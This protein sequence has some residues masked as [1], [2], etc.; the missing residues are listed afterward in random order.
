MRYRN[1]KTLYKSHFDSLSAAVTSF[2]FP[3]KLTSVYMRQS[4]V[5]R[6]YTSVESANSAH[7]ERLT[8]IS[9]VIS[10]ALI[11]LVAFCLAWYRKWLFLLG[12][13]LLAEYCP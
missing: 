10:L 13:G 6:Q 12:L 9:I 5:A 11:G 8:L 1:E 2:A 4:C 3:V 7:N